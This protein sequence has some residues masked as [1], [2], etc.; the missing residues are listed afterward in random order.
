[1]RGRADDG[2]LGVRDAEHRLR[3]LAVLGQPGHDLFG[4]WGGNEY[5]IAADSYP[6]ADERAQSLDQGGGLGYR[7]R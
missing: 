4:R 3:A 2:L 6:Q 7:R 5:L 1:L